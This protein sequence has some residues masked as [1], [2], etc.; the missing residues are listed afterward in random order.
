MPDFVVFFLVKNLFNTVILVVNVNEIQKM[1]FHC[2]VILTAGKELA[3]FL[4]QNP[5]FLP[6]GQDDSA[7]I[8]QFSIFHKNVRISPNFSIFL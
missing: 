5:Q 1:D 4:F 2:A 7:G 8:G 3:L 6:C